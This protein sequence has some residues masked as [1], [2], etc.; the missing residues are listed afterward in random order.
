MANV[1]AKV[2]RK[3]KLVGTDNVHTRAC[4]R[5]LHHEPFLLSCWLMPPTQVVFV[6]NALD[7]IAQYSGQTPAKVDKKARPRTACSQ[8]LPS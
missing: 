8:T 1:V 2:M 3:M 6:N 7:L 4:L 5:C